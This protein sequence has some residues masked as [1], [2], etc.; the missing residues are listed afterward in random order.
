MG[1]TLKR[2]PRNTT[3]TVVFIRKSN[4]EFHFPGKV[5]F[6]A[7]NDIPLKL[8]TF[9]LKVGKEGHISI[10]VVT[11]VSQ[12]PADNIRIYDSLHVKAQKQHVN[13]DVAQ[14]CW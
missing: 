3:G 10:V 2:S 4:G 9:P 5:E 7:K 13:V 1:T 14:Y 11:I 8:A 6:R 12:K